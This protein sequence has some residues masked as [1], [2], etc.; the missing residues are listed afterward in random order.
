MH[1][2]AGAHSDV[3]GGYVDGHLA[4]IPLLWMAG[5][6]ASTGLVFDPS[7]LPR[8]EALDPLAGLHESRRGFSLKDRLTPTIRRICERDIKVGFHERLYAPRGAAGDLLPT[9]NEGIHVSLAR[10]WRQIGQM[11]IDDGS[12]TVDMSYEPRNLGPLFRPD[13]RVKQGVKLFHTD[14]LP[15]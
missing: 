11:S 12:P 6:A 10:R 3:G 4:D 13:G 7:V 1:W 15:S 14:P 5:R 8:P 9:I 2:F